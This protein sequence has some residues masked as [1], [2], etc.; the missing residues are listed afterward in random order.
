MSCLF[1]SYDVPFFTGVRSVG[2]APVA[3]WRLGWVAVVRALA[4]QVE[5]EVG[6]Y[7]AHDFTIAAIMLDYHDEDHLEYF[8]PYGNG[9]PIVQICVSK[10]AIEEATKVE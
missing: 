6:L 5:T 8:E 4:W 2:N 1:V 9:N 3:L 7:C 10:Q